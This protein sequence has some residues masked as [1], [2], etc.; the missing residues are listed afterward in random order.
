M[1][2]FDL[3]PKLNE[4]IM[5]DISLLRKSFILLSLFAIMGQLNGQPNDNKVIDQQTVL[6]NTYQSN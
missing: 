3:N 2:C 5:S 6:N 4:K 1:T